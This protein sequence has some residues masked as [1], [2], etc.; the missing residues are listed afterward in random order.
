MLAKIKR[1]PPEFANPT[2][3]RHAATAEA[4]PT[5]SP[6]ASN[7]VDKE[8]ERLRDGTPNRRG[9]EARQPGH[10]NLVGWLA[11]VCSAGPAFTRTRLASPPHRTRTQFNPDV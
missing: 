8:W 10:S 7:L 11:D 1:M 6:W 5:P 3:S 9:E 2:A 4:K